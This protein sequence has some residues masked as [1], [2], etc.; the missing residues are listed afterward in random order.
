M[1]RIE[2]PIDALTQLSRKT[3]EKMLA[4]RPQLISRVGEKLKSVVVESYDRRAAGGESVGIT[5]EPL[6]EK[7]LRRKSRKGL[8]NKIGIATGRLKESIT[9]EENSGEVVL[10]FTA[11]HAVAFNELRQLLPEQL[12]KEWQDQVESVA[13]EWADEILVEHFEDEVPF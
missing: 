12:P 5:W 8:S 6:T 1:F 4:D 7:Y 3:R 9:V 2:F 13:T 10:T 11:D